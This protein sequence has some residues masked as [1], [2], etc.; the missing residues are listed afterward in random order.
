MTPR[1]PSLGVAH[2]FAVVLPTACAVSLSIALAK[3][4]NVDVSPAGLGLLL[5]GVFGTYCLDS[6]K[7]FRRM[8]F[9]RWGRGCQAGFFLTIPVILLFLAYLP[10]AFGP[11]VVLA[12]ISLAYRYLKQILPKEI[13]VA[14]GWTFALA[15]LPVQDWRAEAP[16]VLLLSGI[17]L[18][19]TANVILC[20]L[21]D[22]EIDSRRAIV[23]AVQCLGA[24]RAAWLARACAGGAMV[25]CMS[26]VASPVQALFW[27]IPA[28]VYLV[29]PSR[30]VQ[31]ASCWRL[32]YDGVL[33]VPAL[34]GLA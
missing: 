30:G 20:D 28:S 17:L 22:V 27:L 32:I 15:A 7:D 34:A 18:L 1:K 6:A 9:Q 33:L 8:G 16:T 12:G 2:A 4:L 19:L 5:S 24:V 29:A 11:L 25:L 26:G 10:R 13:L 21:L 23:C 3:G 31:Q 14:G